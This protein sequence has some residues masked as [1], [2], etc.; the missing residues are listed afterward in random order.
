MFDFLKKTI[1]S[2]IG[3]EKKPVE[4]KG[5]NQ[6]KKKN[7][8]NTK[9]KKIQTK[10]E[11]KIER[12]VEA[13]VTEATPPEA[14]KESFFS[15]LM[16]KLTAA[17][18]SEADF[19]EAFADLEITL[20][21]N[22]TAVKAVEAIKTSLKKEL[23]GLNC[24]KNEA[25]ERILSSLKEALS[26]ILQEPPS[27]LT[28]VKSKQPFVILFFGINGTGKTTSIAK[29][30]HYL[31]KNNLSSVLV[32]GDTF[33]AASI[34][35]L[36]HHAKVLK[37]P[38]IKGE[39]NADP[40]SIAYNGLEYAKAHN[41]QVVLIDTAGRMYTKTNLMKEMEKI[42]RIAKP[43]LKLFVG[44][45]ITGNDVIEQANTFNETAGIDGI[46]L[47]KADIDKKAG[48]ILSVSQVVNK[49]LY[50]LGTGQGYKDL[51]PFTKK[52]V[53]KNLGLE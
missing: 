22:N 37:I 53:L 2:W 13:I 14:K 16:T 32:A 30:A 27:F 34:E 20:L 4:K 31:Q 15:K 44:E 35:Q 6:I 17:K 36:E 47:T 39:Y 38:C 12:E 45:S 1:K 28:Q 10:T 21:E 8:V 49:P 25:S 7:T 42:I 18:L 50:F 52:E 48:A 26:S 23:V 5:K 51:L 40:A 41:I 11:E 33:R 46:I 29:V 9:T 43:D 24:K 3:K 19:E